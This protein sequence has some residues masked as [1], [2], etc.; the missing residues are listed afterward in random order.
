MSKLKTLAA[1]A[2]LVGG[3][4]TGALAQEATYAPEDT[5]KDGYT[6]PSEWRSEHAP[7]PGAATRID[8]MPSDT[9]GDSRTAPEL[10]YRAADTDGDGYVNSAEWDRY[11][12]EVMNSLRERGVSRPEGE[13]SYQEADL[14]QDGVVS[15]DEWD[16]YHGRMT[17]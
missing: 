4:S 9:A 5:N 11:H 6:S 13:F 14:N 17:R 3:A 10:S 2:L 16:R 7:A 15:N 1:A 12:A 8:A